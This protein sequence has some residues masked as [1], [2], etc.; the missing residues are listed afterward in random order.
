MTARVEIN[1]SV[2]VGGE[3]PLTLLGG[4][5]VIE[6][7]AHCLELGEQIR[8]ACA[9]RGVQYVFKASYDKANRTSLSSYRGPGLECGL[10]TLDAV[11]R[12]LGVPVV[13]DI[14]EPEHAAIAAPVVDVLQIPAFL[15]RQT[16][17]LLAAAATGRVV[18]VK[19]GQFLAADDMRFVVQKLVDGGTE[20]VLVTERGTTFGY[21]NLVVDFRSLEILRTFGFPVV[22]DATHS[23]QMPGAGDGASSGDRRYVEPLARAAVAIGVDALFMEIHDD[24]DRAPS[25]G[26]NMVRLDALP[27]LLD[28][29]LLVR[30]AA[31]AADALVAPTS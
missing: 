9:T 26:P 3:G 1:S 5:C 13:T 2:G 30:Q 15:C 11:R 14:H 6:S 29:L 8:V 16:D 28:R 19:K 21:H 10:Q 27:Q 12:S 7:E 4:P 25:D 22:F 18:N 31:R 23:V 24:P 17:L 20:R